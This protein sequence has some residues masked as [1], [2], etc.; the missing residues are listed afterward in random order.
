MWLTLSGF[1]RYPVRALV[2]LLLVVARVPEV[3]AGEDERFSLKG[4]LS[5][6]V[7]FNDETLDTT[8]VGTRYLPE[9][10]FIHAL[11]GAGAFDAVASIDA[12][13]APVV[14]DLDDI[15]D[16]SDVD[17]Y[18]LWTRYS[19]SQFEARLGL[20]KINF[21]PAKLLRALMWFDRLDVRDPLQLTDGVYGGLM[22]YWFV[23]NSNIWLWGLYGNDDPKGREVFGSDEHEPEFGGRYQFSVP[24]GEMA[25]SGHHRQVDREQWDAQVS[26][27]LED[28]TE[29]RFAI[30]GQW[31]LVV[32]LWFEA[33]AAETDIG[34]GQ[35]LSR[36]FITV[37]GDYTFESGV[38]VLCEQ[39]RTSEG[40]RA[41]RT[42]D[43]AD[44]T[45]VMVDYR[46]GV[47]DSF[48]GIAY[49][50]WEPDDINWHLGWR[51]TYDN[52]RFDVSVFSAAVDDAMGTF[53]GNGMQ[54]MLTYNH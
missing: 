42:G 16:R 1:Q 5:G 39:G 8:V 22:R 48:T 44:L 23:D 36:R 37:G 24:A 50:N 21:G 35:S 13:A 38:H 34:S 32:G 52:W 31:D 19:T 9:A 49:Y 2:L 7:E 25:F 3:R 14:D 11:P 29:E 41:R 45:A 27:P 20:Q 46:Y 54:L 12:Y 15:S 28:G 43:H 10:R 17:L 6:W 4:Q 40:S 53:A 18:R 51:R 33:S 30:E 26:I 47:V